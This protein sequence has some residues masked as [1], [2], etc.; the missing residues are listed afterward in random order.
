MLLHYAVEKLLHF[1]SMLL[2]FAATLITSCVGITI[3][4]VTVGSKFSPE[5]LIE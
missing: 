4:G 3:C 5:N 2:H 1:A